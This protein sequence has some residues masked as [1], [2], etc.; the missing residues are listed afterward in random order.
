MET[1]DKSDKKTCQNGIVQCPDFA[2]HIRYRCSCHLEL[3]SGLKK[4]LDDW[5][6]MEVIFKHK[7]LLGLEICTKRF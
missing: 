7:N 6:P 4:N 1:N 5:T 3:D 2:Q